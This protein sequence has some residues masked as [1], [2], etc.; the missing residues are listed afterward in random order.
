ME[1]LQFDW[2]LKGECRNREKKDYSR[3]M[4]HGSGKTQ[5]PSEDRGSCLTARGQSVSAL[6]AGQLPAG[7]DG[8]HFTSCVRKPRVLVSSSVVSAT[9]MKLHRKGFVEIIL[10]RK[11]KQR[12]WIIL[13]D[14]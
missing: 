14:N 7:M 11:L 6:A 2:S 9:G 5:G 10:V 8:G 3:W 1:S 13:N 12:V 4:Q